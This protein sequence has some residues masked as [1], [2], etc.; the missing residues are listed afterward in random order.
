MSKMNQRKLQDLHVVPKHHPTSYWSHCSDPA[1]PLCSFAMPEDRD[2]RNKAFLG[3]SGLL[4][5]LS[6]TELD[7]SWLGREYGGEKSP[8]WS[9]QAGDVAVLEHWMSHPLATVQAWGTASV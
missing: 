3:L 5:S 9:S 6:V 8:E 7:T 2:T 1:G 4:H